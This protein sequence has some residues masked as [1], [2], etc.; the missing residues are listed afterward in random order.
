MKKDKKSGP[1]RK[2][3]EEAWIGD[4]VLDLFARTWILERKGSLC[5]ET[6]IRMTSNQFLSCFG[7]PTSVEAKIGR[8]YREKGLEDAFSW[9]ESE[10]LPLFEK[11][12][13]KRA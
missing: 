4:T 9:I 5:G 10:L 8:I 7:N 6:L 2:E 11:Q 3:Q 1:I 12:E 13:K